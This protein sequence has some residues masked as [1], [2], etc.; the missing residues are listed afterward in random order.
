[1]TKLPE[2]VLKRIEE[3][4]EAFARETYQSFTPVMSHEAGSG[5]RDYVI[6]AIAEAERA[7]ELVEAA[8]KLLWAVQCFIIQSNGNV[9][10]LTKEQVFDGAMSAR[11]T[12]KL[13]RAR[14][15]SATS[16][17]GGE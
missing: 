3:N 13:I 2:E 14:Y 17:G 4:A 7:M 11:D 12:F 5:K 9:P 8:D 1:M 6:G 16:A 10:G 15:R